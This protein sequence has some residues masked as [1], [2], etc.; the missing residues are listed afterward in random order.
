MDGEWTKDVWG[1]RKFKVEGECPYCGE[2]LEPEIRASESGKIKYKV[3]CPRCGFKGKGKV[4]EPII[5]GM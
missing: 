5:R 3:H 1:V 4:D 2:S